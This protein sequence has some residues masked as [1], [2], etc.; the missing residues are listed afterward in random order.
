VPLF[1]RV[2]TPQEEVITSERN[3]FGV[4]RVERHELG[5]RLVHGNTIH[6]MQLSG[7]RSAQPTTYYSE[8]SG[9]GRTFAALQEARPN[10]H[11]GVVG[12]GCGVLATYGRQGDRFDLIEINPAVIDIAKSHFSFL[13]DSQAEIQNHLGD[14]RL[15]LERMIDIKFDL[16]VLD[17]FSS[18]AIPAHL[19]TRESMSLY[20]SRIKSDGVLAIHVS[21]NHLDLTPL[22][23]RLSAD[24]GLQSGLIRSE[25]DKEIGAQS[26][27]WVVVTRPDHE[28]WSNE[29]MADAVGPSPE[30]LTDGPLWTDQH[31]N[32]VSVLR[33]W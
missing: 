11:I 29:R 31:H 9:I 14:G 13:S 22:V 32:L 30:D 10:L 2:V 24:A 15:V 28:L 18:D 7:D 17:A 26:A 8:P 21:N 4:L 20:K 3:F 33:L 23:H 25:S 12:L 6:G 19:L 27:L 16:L 1:A 5:I